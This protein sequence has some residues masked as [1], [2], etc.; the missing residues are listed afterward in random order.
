[1]K[2][3]VSAVAVVV[4]LS[5][6]GSSSNPASGPDVRVHLEQVSGPPDVYYFAGPVNIQYRLSIANPTD[7]PLTLTRLDLQTL[8]SGAYSLR[9][10]ATPMNLKVP[11]NANASYLIS[12][13]G[14]ANGGYLSAGEP[15]TIRGTAY[16]QSQT[17]KKSFVRLFTENITP[18]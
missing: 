7:E 10:A 16:F 18:A 3:A 13:W 12:V 5:G 9:A 8:G 1:M 15:V 17:T 6:C 11:P 4:L 14:R 2:R